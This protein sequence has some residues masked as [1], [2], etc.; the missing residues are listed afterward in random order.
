M[1]SVPATR[2]EVHVDLAGGTVRAGT[3]H[4]ATRRGETVCTFTYDA[5]YLG[6]PDSFDLGPDLP[7]AE[8]SVTTHGLPGA[9]R[10]SAPDRWGGHLI[11]RR[12][13]AEDRDARR[14]PRTLTDVDYLL[15]VSDLTRQGAMRYR[16]GGGD[17]VAT[18]TDV[19]KLLEL[20][21]L[22]HAATLVA[23]GAGGRDEFAAIKVLVDAGTGSLGGARPKAS[24]RDGQRLLIA[25]FPHPHDEWDVEAWEATALDL[26]HA[27]G[28]AVP[29]HEL[30]DV[31]GHSVLLL[32]RFDRREGR[33]VPYASAMTLMRT[34]DGVG[35]DYTELAESLAAQGSRVTADL[36][37]LWRR[38]AFSLV[39]NNC[40]DHLR[41]HGFLFDDGGW[42]ASPLFDVNPNPDPRVERATSIGFA[43]DSRETPTAL[44]AAARDFR[45]TPADARRVW[46]EVL[47]A[48]EGWRA[49]AAANGVSARELD[50]FAEALDQHH[51]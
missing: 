51:R 42:A 1:S 18:G 46:D 45:L 4:V 30:V 10:D 47:A 28:I 17:F 25:K 44:F 32:E 14:T 37:D 13:H 19:P 23:R 16:Q 31:D 12:V 39:V 20:P 3:A 7:R 11:A 34:T 2:F 36:R 21:T 9:L 41:N 22:L 27:A 48:T 29:R 49:V 50:D 43:T 6:S 26:A 15:G 33:R 24:V 35:H 38:V 40:D 5:D 8:I